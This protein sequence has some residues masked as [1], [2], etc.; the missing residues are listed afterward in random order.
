MPLRLCS[1]QW[2]TWIKF[3]SQML[4]S[5]PFSQE[6]ALSAA[7]CSCRRRHSSASWISGHDDMTSQCGSSFVAAYQMSIRL[8]S[9]ISYLCKLAAKWPGAVWSQF[10]TD[11]NWWGRSKPGRGIIGS[12]TVR[13]GWPGRLTGHL[14]IQSSKKYHLHMLLSYNTAIS[15]VAA[16]TPSSKGIFKVA[17]PAQ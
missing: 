14:A 8:D 12:E 13:S 6:S 7:G 2:K 16:N 10:S 15:H 1:L 5:T 17:A 11:H 4:S 9:A 3:T